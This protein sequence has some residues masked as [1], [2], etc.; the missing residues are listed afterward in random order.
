MS[1]TR[2]PS[3]SQIT[4]G[5]F[6]LDLRSGGL[7][8]S[9]ARLNL[10]HQPLQLLSVLLERPGELVSREELR[11]RRGGVIGSSLPSAAR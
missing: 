11:K 10:Q 5:V 9:G 4:F 8:K 1:E 6:E 7:R 2:A 3:Q